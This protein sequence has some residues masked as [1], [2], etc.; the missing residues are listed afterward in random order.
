MYIQKFYNTK[1]ELNR[2]EKELIEPHLGKD[3]CL[4]IAEGGYGGDTFSGRSHTEETKAKISATKRKGYKKENHPNYGKH[5]SKETIEKISNSK[6]GK[7]KGSENGFAKPTTIINTHTNETMN[8]GCA[9]DCCDFLH[10]S[11]QGEQYQ[12]FLKGI[13]PRKITDWKLLEPPTRA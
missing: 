8:F 9:K 6:Q 2:A 7:Y 13:L 11:K 4:N 12:R 1:E 10:I 5:L 3:Y